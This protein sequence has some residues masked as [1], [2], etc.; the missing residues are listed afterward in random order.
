MKGLA[1]RIINSIYP[2]VCPV[3]ESVVKSPGVCGECQ[4]KIIIIKDTGCTVCGKPLHNGKTLKCDA[5]RKLSRSFDKNYV[6]FEYAG[7]IK[8]SI[9]R[10]K[11]QNT[12]NYGEAYASVFASE[13]GK[14]ITGRNIDA[15]IPVPMAAAKLKKRGYNQAEVWARALSNELAIPLDFKS[16]I[17]NRDTL[18]MKELSDRQRIDNLK[19]AFSIDKSAIGKYD[20]VLLV[21]DIYTTGAT[22]DECASLLK[23]SGVKK[24]YCAC[25][26]AGEK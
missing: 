16:M 20:N 18:P 13:Y 3:C 5:C 11:Y 26:A 2:C 24:V 9:Y 6:L 4:E 8:K 1:R 17:R 15:I 23:K 12:R 10:F 25:I 21:D 14:E 7:D 19:G 22:L